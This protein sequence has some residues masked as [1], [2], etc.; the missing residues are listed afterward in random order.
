MITQPNN[1]QML[2]K[3][4]LSRQPNHN[5]THAAHFQNGMPPGLYAGAGNQPQFGGL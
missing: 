4:E 2:A 1:N 5:G 3:D